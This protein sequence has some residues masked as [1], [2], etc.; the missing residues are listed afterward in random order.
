MLV[1]LTDQNDGNS[2][3]RC[4][5]FTEPSRQLVITTSRCS[6]STSSY[7]CTPSVVK[8]RSSFNPAR[9]APFALPDLPDAWLVPTVSVMPTPS[10]QRCA[11]TH[12]ALAH[13]LLSPDD[14][15][16]S[17]SSCCDSAIAARNSAISFSKSSMDEKER[18]TLA[19]RR[20]ATPSS[21]RSGPRMASPTSW[22]GT[23]AKPADRMVSSTLCASCC[24]SS[25]LTGRP[26]HARRT[27]STTFS[28]LNCSV[29]PDRF[30]TAS[31][32][33]SDVV[34]LRP[35]F[36]HARRRRIAWPSSTSRESTTRE[37]SCL[38]NG[39]RMPRPPGP[40]RPRT[41]PP[42]TRPASVGLP[43]RGLVIVLWIDGGQPT[44]CCGQLLRQQ[45]KLWNNYTHVTTTCWGR[46]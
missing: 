2:T 35:H 9:L 16:P 44:A 33:V 8:T 36:E 22:L 11:P 5:K 43:G 37:S 1:A 18:Y 32:T 15:P 17:A 42:I 14:A 20:Y 24:R 29:T 46:H 6:H 39:H 19:N 21:S 40:Q 41:S 34:N 25:S 3:P 4:S 31:T 12:R 10:L 30:T 28:R 38:Q 23:S 27:P 26:L 13:F 7:G 45:P